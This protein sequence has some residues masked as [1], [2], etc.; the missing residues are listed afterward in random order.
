MAAGVVI[1]TFLES[2][3]AIL[4]CI[5]AMEPGAWFGV[6][7]S[8]GKAFDQSN[9]PSLRE[10]GRLKAGFQTRF[11]E[12]LF[13]EA[14]WLT[15]LVFLL[16]GRLVAAQPAESA[17]PVH[18]VDGSFVREWLVLGPFPSENLNLDFLVEAGGEANIRPK[19]GDTLTTSDG[20]RLVW[21]RLRSNHDFVN[22]EQ[23]FGIRERAV[24]YAYCEL[25]SDQP[26][27][28]DVRFWARTLASVRINGKEAGET[29]NQVSRNIYIPLVLPIQLNAGRNACLLKLKAVLIEEWQFL[30][31]PLPPGRAVAELHVTDPAQK[32]VAGGPGQ[33]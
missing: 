8:A 12:S 21:T 11:T 28:S 29:P 13:G 33:F 23:V 2:L 32:N 4:A 22:L 14:V 6:P 20:T 25:N 31:Q 5:R 16:P 17:A 3:Q 7:A 1:G 18:N 9:A 26:S 24:A 19:E 30:F 15:M 10:P 27:E